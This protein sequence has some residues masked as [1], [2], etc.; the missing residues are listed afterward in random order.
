MPI[1]PMPL[2]AMLRCYMHGNFL[3]IPILP[4]AAITYSCNAHCNNTP[5]PQCS[6][7]TRVAN[8]LLVPILYL[9]QQLLT[10][11]MPIVPIPLATMLCHYTHGQ[12]LLVPILLTA[13]VTYSSNAHCAN[14]FGHNS[15]LLHGQKFFAYTNITYSSNYLQQQCPL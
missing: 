3:F 6:T 2:A 9:L 7:T 1:A 10:A 5:W 12:F 14:T 15:L 11:A 13:A 4:T 8:F